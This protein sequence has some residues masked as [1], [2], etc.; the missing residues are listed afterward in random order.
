VDDHI[1]RIG[2]CSWVDVVAH[3]QKCLIDGRPT[4]IITVIHKI[5]G[6]IIYC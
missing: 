6:I 4:E 1:G 5:T 3:Q 2:G